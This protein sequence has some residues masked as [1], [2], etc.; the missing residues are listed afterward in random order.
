MYTCSAIY[1]RNVVTETTAMAVS[2]IALAA[3]QTTANRVAALVAVAAPVAAPVA[4]SPVAS[5]MAVVVE[6]PLVFA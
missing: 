2:A 1:T 5:P 4:V 6:M 3:T